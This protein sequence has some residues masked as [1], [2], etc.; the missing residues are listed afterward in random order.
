MAVSRSF[1]NE[2]RG[3]VAVTFAVAALPIML[4]AGAA[5][6]YSAANRS[7]A[8]LDSFADAAVLAVTSQSAM[9]MTADAAQTRAVDY[10]NSQAATLKRGTV[11]TAAALKGQ[12]S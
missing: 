5:I 10:F 6:D 2:H 3:N 1:L 8:A 7:K 4:A 9:S 11:L 12:E